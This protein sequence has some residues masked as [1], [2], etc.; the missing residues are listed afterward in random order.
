[1][2]F[3]KVA[4]ENPIQVLKEK[5]QVL[6]GH[7]DDLDDYLKKLHERLPKIHC[8]KLS[9]P[10]ERPRQALFSIIGLT[11]SDNS[12]YQQKTAAIATVRATCRVRLDEGYWRHLGATVFVC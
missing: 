7:F 5:V 8:G 9:I 10:F 1:M 6:K 3:R 4:T 11:K 12:Y 2:S